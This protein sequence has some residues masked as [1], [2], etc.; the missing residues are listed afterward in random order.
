VDADLRRLRHQH[1][2]GSGHRAAPDA[3]RGVDWGLMAWDVSDAL[4]KGE[5]G[6]DLDPAAIREA[7]P[8]FVADVLRTQ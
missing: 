4:D 3:P 2:E 6:L 5:H 7:L 8:A 1:P